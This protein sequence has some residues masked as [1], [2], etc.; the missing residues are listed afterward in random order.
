MIGCSGRDKGKANADVFRDFIARTDQEN[1]WSEYVTLDGKKIS[2]S[3]VLAACGFSRSVLRQN[4]VVKEHLIVL[5]SRLRSKGVLG[6]TPLSNGRRDG[7]KV[8]EIETDLSVLIEALSQARDELNTYQ[9]QIEA[10]A[11]GS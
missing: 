4:P 11:K 6:G 2:R 8:E 9:Q 7:I 3:K 10:V 1:S 5:E